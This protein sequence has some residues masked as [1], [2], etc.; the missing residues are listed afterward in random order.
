MRNSHTSIL[1]QQSALLV[2]VCAQLSTPTPSTINDQVLDHL[3]VPDTAA[4]LDTAGEMSCR[5]AWMLSK[6]FWRSGCRFYILR[7][8]VAGTV[9]VFA[10]RVPNRAKLGTQP[11][12]GTKIMSLPALL[13]AQLP[14]FQHSNVF[15]HTVG[16]L[17]YLKSCK[18]ATRL[19]TT[20]LH[21]ENVILF[22]AFLAILPCEKA[23]S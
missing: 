2:L 10:E 19:T 14:S 22:V 4:T 7:Q 12:M 20:L 16:S 5:F 3:R 21:Q 1:F 17:I 13:N 18:S 23:K 8:G 11:I 9:N 6:M 15:I